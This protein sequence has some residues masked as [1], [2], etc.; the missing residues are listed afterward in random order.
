MCKSYALEK[1]CKFEAGCD[2]SHKEETITNK[3]N[4]KVAELE[5]IVNGM[6]RKIVEL[7]NKVKKMESKEGEAKEMKESAK[8]V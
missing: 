7:E 1:F 5:Q 8:I 6:S 4:M 2:Y 3:Y